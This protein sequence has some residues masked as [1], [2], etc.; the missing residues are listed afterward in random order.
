MTYP[1]NTCPKYIPIKIVDR[2]STPEKIAKF[3]IS[4]PKNSVAGKRQ[5]TQL[6]PEGL[7][8]KFVS[9]S[10]AFTHR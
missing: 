9:D 1:K 10:P 8:V 5:S 7:Y 4:N 3:K 2:S 6:G